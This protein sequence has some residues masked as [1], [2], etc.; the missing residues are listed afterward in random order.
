[1]DGP[2]DVSIGGDLALSWGGRKIFCIAK[3]LNYLFLGKKLSIFMPKI[4]DDLKF[5]VIDYIFQIFP[6][7]TVCEM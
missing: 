4:L 2:Y 3:F 6:V 1:M 5:L 7:F